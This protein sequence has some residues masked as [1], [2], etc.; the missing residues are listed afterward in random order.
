MNICSKLCGECPFSNKSIQGYLANYDVDDIKNFMDSEALFPCHKMMPD[1][2]L[3]QDEVQE[4]IKN[5]ELKLCRGYMESMI[6][7]CKMPKHNKTLSEAIALVK[8]QGLSDKSMDI[9][10]F[11]KYHNS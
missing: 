4:L 9:R 10:Q 5:G 1:E 6:K 8:E 2:D 7:S 3:D 11:I